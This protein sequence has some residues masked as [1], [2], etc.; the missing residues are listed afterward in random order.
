MATV[1][2]DGHT[3]EAFPVTQAGPRALWDEIAA[4]QQWVQMG[5]PGVDQ[6]GT[7]VTA[8]GEST[9]WV[10]I[11]GEGVLPIAAPDL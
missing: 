10:E 2:Y 5:R 3:T 1:D 7:A 6:Y 4:Y 11:P 9:V 8:D